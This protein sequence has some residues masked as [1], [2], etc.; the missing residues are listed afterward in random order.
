MQGSDPLVRRTAR[1]R[2]RHSAALAPQPPAW[3]HLGVQAQTG[4]PSSTLT[5]Y[6]KALAL[7]RDLDGTPLRW[8]DAPR[9][10]LAFTRGTALTCRVNFTDDAVPLPA[11]ETVL[12][13]SGPLDGHRL[14]PHTAVWTGDR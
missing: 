5:L 12:L 1:P 4:D 9:D 11:D 10:V 14:P 8:I 7:R 13:T 6:R 3:R 2:V